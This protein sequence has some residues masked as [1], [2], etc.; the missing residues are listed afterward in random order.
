MEPVAFSSARSGGE[1][2]A[3]LSVFYDFIFFLLS[4]PK[5]D[6]W[7]L[8]ILRFNGTAIRAKFGKNLLHMSHKPNNDL[9]SVKLD[10]V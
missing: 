2:S 3:F 10:G 7:S 6:A 4:V 1:V 5:V 9:G 8:Q